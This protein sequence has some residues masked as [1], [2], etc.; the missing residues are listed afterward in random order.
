MDSD[1]IS[2]QRKDNLE[3]LKTEGGGG[4]GGGGKGKE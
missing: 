1:G 2:L 4:G 3:H